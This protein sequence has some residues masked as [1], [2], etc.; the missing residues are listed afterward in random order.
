MR[1]VVFALCLAGPGLSNATAVV[2]T[3]YRFESATVTDL[4]TLGGP[5]SFAHDIN[6]GGDIV[7]QAYDASSKAHAVAWFSGTIYDLHSGTPSWHTATAYSINDQRLVVGKYLQTGMFGKW[8]AFMYYP[9]TWLTPLAGHNPA[10]DLPYVWDTFAYAINN[11]G[12]IA[13]EAIRFPSLPPPP[14][15]GADLCYENLPVQW[16]PGVSD[17]VPLF[18]VTDVNGDNNYN[19]DGSEGTWPKAYDVNE[20]GNFVGNDGAS[21]PW[22]MFLFKDGVRIAV[23]PPAGAPD[24]TLDGEATGINNKNWVVGTFGWPTGAQYFRGFVW[25]GV[26]ANSVNLGMLP[27]GKHSYAEEINE[28]NMVA[29][30]SERGYGPWPMVRSAGYIW[31]SD[32]GM[33]QLPGLGGAFGLANGH[34]VYMYDSCWALS[35]NDRKKTTGMVQ[36]VGWCDVGGWPHAVRW[37][38]KISIVPALPIAPLP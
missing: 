34:L 1:L 24:M 33:K 4:G 22:S 6:E 35:L 27:G 25:D 30:T 28:Q 32:F 13:G 16:M 7:G 37:D 38:V 14:D 17:P 11:S 8:R 3:K 31:H 2:P 10:P 36:V 29:G 5:M 9:G 19:P 20:S 26:S 18:C 12:R 15:T 21:T 23:P